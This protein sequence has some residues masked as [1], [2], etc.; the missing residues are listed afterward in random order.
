MCA[1]LSM[2]RKA[3]KHVIDDDFE[4]YIHLCAVNGE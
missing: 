2:S 1:L 3:E 4:V